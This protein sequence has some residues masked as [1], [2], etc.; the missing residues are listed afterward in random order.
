M[1]L[2][3]IRQTVGQPAFLRV[4]ISV[5]DLNLVPQ[6]DRIAKF[7]SI[8]VISLV[9]EVVA[10]KLDLIAFA[11][12]DQ[13]LCLRVRFP[14]HVNHHR[15]GDVAVGMVLVKHED[16]VR[17]RAVHDGRNIAD[18]R[19]A[20]VLLHRPDPV[21]GHRLPVDGKPCSV[22]FVDQVVPLRLDLG[23][24][25][26][27]NVAFPVVE[28]HVL[29]NVDQV[30]QLFVRK[31][32]PAVFPLK[33][34]RVKVVLLDVGRGGFGREAPPDEEIQDASRPA[35]AAAPAV[36]SAQQALQP[37]AAVSAADAAV[38]ASAAAAEAFQQAAQGASAEAA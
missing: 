3:N 24:K 20:G 37:A 23:V 10:Y 19:V 33:H 21:V 9:V 16:Q 12:A 15:P 38:A 14:V 36:I 27:I 4:D 32:N 13:V 2:I 31:G 1:P 26:H 34:T 17:P 6:G 22:E 35:G 11:D 8:L 25:P 29:L 7:I 5:R 28:E 30:A 18:L